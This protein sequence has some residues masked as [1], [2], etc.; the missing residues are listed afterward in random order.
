MTY[1]S[2]A[3]LYDRLMDD[4]PYPSWVE[5]V[6]R[7]CQKHNLGGNPS[8]LDLACGTGSLSLLLHE[9]GYRVTGVDLSE[10]M[11]SVAAVKAGEAGAAIP[12]YQQDMRELEGFDPFDVITIFCDSLNY[13]SS[14]DDVH[15]TFRR[16][17]EHVKEGGLFLFD[18]HSIY[19][20]SQIFMNQ[21]FSGNEEDVSYIWNCF[22]GEHPNSVEH[23]LTFF[24]R[25]DDD[26]YERFDE[27]HQ[28]R[29]FS[30]LDYK[31]WLE[32]AGFRNIEV[33]S[34]FGE[35]LSDEAERIFFAAQK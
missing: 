31:K 35:T 26:L 30:V 23:D 15:R 28:Q 29:T 14:E 32:E 18:V 34:D 33:T 12:F 2:F 27:L 10:D 17:F 1:N 7:Y 13:L 24:M 20:I 19:K 8:L 6:N 21:T 4:V 9:A 11:L 5:L 25:N 22:P 3:Y 16:A